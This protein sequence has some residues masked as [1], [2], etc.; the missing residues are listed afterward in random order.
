VSAIR[1]YALTLGHPPLPRSHTYNQVRAGLNN[2]YGDTNFSQPRQGITIDDLCQLR[3]HLDLD[4][5]ADARDW[6]AYLF[7]FYG[8]LRIKE[9]TCGGL[10]VCHISLHTWGISLT[11]P[12]SKTSLIP[13]KVEIIRRDDQL[14]PVHA[15]LAYV[16]LLSGPRLP[17]HPFF[18][19]HAHSTAALSDTVFTRRL[20]RLVQQAL[21]GDPDAYAGHSFRRGGT[22]ALLQ[23]GVP[24]A[25]IA[26]HGRWKSLAYRG[27]FDVQHSLR[28]RLA[29]TAQLCLS[30]HRA[31]KSG[32]SAFSSLP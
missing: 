4:S 1:N 27:Y 14:C 15:Y 25:T 16:A 7:A 17:H 8:L 9:Y 12:F 28:L 10:S 6:C 24:E 11:V 19:R 30:S 32:G 18:L 29:A 5:F 22:S 23:A 13:T 31:S 20:R 2:W 21:H 3:S 26:S